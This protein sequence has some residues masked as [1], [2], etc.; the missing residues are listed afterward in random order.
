[1]GIGVSVFLLAVGG[2]LSFAVSD[3][4]SGVDLTVVGYILMGAGALGLIMAVLITSQRSRAT[5][6]SVTEQRRYEE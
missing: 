6:T 4:I 3:R 1:M 2:I 5:H